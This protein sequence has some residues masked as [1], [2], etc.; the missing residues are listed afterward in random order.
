MRPQPTL[1][2]ELLLVVTLAGSLGCKVTGDDIEYWKGTVKGPGKIVAVILSDAYPLELR[3]QGALALVEMERS[4]V[5]GVAE[6]QR[7][8]QQLDPE[9]RQ[10][11]IDGMSEGLEQLMRGGDTAQADPNIGPPAAQ[12]RAKD[13]AYLLITHAQGPTRERLVAAVVGWYVADFNG[14]SLAGNY[15]AEQIIRS[16]GAQAAGMLVDGMNAQMPQPALVK[17]AELIAQ[18]G[19][20]ETKQRAAAR[21]VEIEQHMEG[22]EFLDWLKGK[23]VEAMH[24]QNP[25]AQIDQNRVNAIATLNRESF[26]TQG[27]LPA[28]KHL[29]SEGVVAERLIAIAMNPDTSEAMVARRQTALQALEGNAKEEHLDRLLE[30]ALS[31]EVP[32]AVRDYA[33][34]RVGDIRSA[35]A[36]PRMWPL[37]EAGDDDAQRIR[38]RAGEMVLAIGGPNVVAEFFTKLPSG[39]DV[40]YEPEELEGYATRMAQMNPAPTNLVRGQLSSPNWYNRVIALRYFERKGTEDD[41]R[42][43][44]RLSRDTAAVKGERWEGMR[45]ADVGDV[46]DQAIEGLRTRLSGGGSENTQG[47]TNGG[48]SE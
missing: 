40:K 45:L 20:D 29:A 22:D 27:A 10:Q 15:S 48:G 26:I 1:I 43:M 34:D 16:L 28:M 23:V 33:F 3:T 36:I 39:A 46:A 32:V 18:L 30:L 6:L 12:I 42:A 24:D 8:V 41:I 2:L 13:A 9:T 17:L 44:Q 4:D 11:I 47:E 7:A 25:D 14:R 35:R 37:V 31:N 5:D 21:L 19:N 38:W